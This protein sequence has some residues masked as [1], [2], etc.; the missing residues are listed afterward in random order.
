MLQAL[1]QLNKIMEK[2]EKSGDKVYVCKRQTLSRPYDLI[3]AGKEFFFWE[4]HLGY[5]SFLK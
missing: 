2:S 4:V 1:S 5:F 3:M